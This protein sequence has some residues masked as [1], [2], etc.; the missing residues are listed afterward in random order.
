MPLFAAG[1]ALA[2]VT[3]GAAL[4]YPLWMQF[5]G[6]QS[7]G[8]G[9]FSPEY[10]SADLASWPAISPMSLAGSPESARLSTGPAEYNT[11]LG[12]PVLVAAIG[13]A[14]WL[15]RRTLVVACVVAG[16][17]MALL[18][19][20]P[21]I[22]IDG[23]RTAIS[24][25]YALLQGLP[26]VDGALPMRFALPLI[27]L[28]ATIFVLAVDRAL[29][30]P[31]RVVRFAVPVAVIAALLPIAPM[32]METAGRP[33]VPDYFAAGHWRDCAG[34]GDVI[35]P[36]PLPTPQEPWPMRYAA[37]VNAE[38]AIPEG[39]FIG[40]YGS[41]GRGSMGTYKQPTSAMLADVAKSGQVPAIDD[42]H[43]AQARA[44]LVFWKASCVVLADGTPNSDPLRATVEGLLGPGNRVADA[45]VWP[46]PWAKEAALQEQATGG[47]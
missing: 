27:P 43:R 35:V 42:N 3:A 39:F 44:D 1:M 19:L 16:L 9:I 17:L 26:V 32:P 29:R 22:V 38:F 20:G 23:E 11:F 36:V 40:P 46:V 34:T 31:E 4:A 45:W 37:A 6:P 33:P 18:S 30:D 13:C 2:I 28:I 47:R 41:G 10:F 14:I 15:W 25:P 5:A 8:N 24:G 21:K 12:W 7:V